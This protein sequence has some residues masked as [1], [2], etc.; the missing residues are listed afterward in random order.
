MSSNNQDNGATMGLAIVI[1]GIALLAIVVYAAAC[2]LAL[3]L[4]I[5]SICAWNKPR[6]I[7]GETFYP[8]EARA[9][10]GAGIVGAIGVPVFAKFCEI[11]FDTRV[12][13]DYWFYLVTGGYSFVSIGYTMH[14]ASE[15]ERQKASKIIDGDIEWIVGPSPLQPEPEAQPE[16]FRFAS[17]DDEDGTEKSEN[18]GPCQGCAYNADGNTRS[19]RE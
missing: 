11:I 3:L 19:W 10:V 15:Q 16:P 12:P 4:T 8:H 5:A 6:R 13:D 1:A 18:N 9:F 7:L 14:L 2:F 17:W